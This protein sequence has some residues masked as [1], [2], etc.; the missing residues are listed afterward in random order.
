MKVIV[1]YEN[2]DLLAR[3]KVEENELN[4]INLI[5]RVTLISALLSTFFAF[6]QNYSQGEI[7]IL[8]HLCR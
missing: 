4:R 6:R 1:E 2:S 8:E 5:F 3:R 7:I